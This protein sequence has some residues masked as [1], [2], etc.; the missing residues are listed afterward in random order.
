MIRES[1]KTLV[2]RT[3]K[4]WKEKG[5]RIGLVPTMGFFHDGHLAL[6]RQAVEKTERVVVSLFV[7]PTQFGPREDL[8]SYPKDLTGDLEKAERI[9]VDLVFCPSSEEMY[10]AGS[11][12][13]V[14]LPELAKRLCGENR[15]IHF[16]GV[17]TVVTKLLNIIEPDFAF[18]GEKDFQQLVIIKR[19]V[20]D[21][22]IP[23][24]I[25]GHPIVREPDGLAMSSRNAYLNSEER[26]AA[27]V[28]F[29]ALNY[30]REKTAGLEMGSILT[31]IVSEASAIITKQKICSIDYLRVAETEQLAPREILE[32]KCRAFGAIRV[33]GRVRLIDNIPI[34]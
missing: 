28:L 9:G 27:L 11:Q 33:N 24:Q 22:D 29:Q 4:S 15:P 14:T 20:R 5:D 10:G 23:V 2:R 17:A 30:I 34:S 3:V 8:S 6:M 1:E 18:F 21:L 12:T 13:Y 7:N 31:D 26:Q 25:M 32:K 19:M 16:Q